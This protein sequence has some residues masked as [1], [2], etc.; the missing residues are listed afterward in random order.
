MVSLRNKTF[1]AVTVSNVE[2]NLSAGQTPHL[3]VFLQRVQ[4]V[5][6]TLN[7]DFY[8]EKILLMKLE[9]H[10]GQKTPAPYLQKN[11]FVN[12]FINMS[13]GCLSKNIFTILQ[14]FFLQTVI[15]KEIPL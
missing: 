9:L 5:Q 8:G 12:T 4:I 13:S 10:V 2:S 1:T 11:S 14:L 6:V 3:H 15:F 7:K